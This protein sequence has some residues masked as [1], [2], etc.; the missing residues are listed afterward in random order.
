MVKEG[1]MAEIFNP[2][3]E[4]SIPSVYVHSGI[5][6]VYVDASPNLHAFVLNYFTYL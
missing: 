6:K 4:F 3:Y 5:I 1:R 2:Q